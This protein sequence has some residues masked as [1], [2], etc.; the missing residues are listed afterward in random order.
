[1]RQTGVPHA[2][3]ELNP[4]VLANGC[5]AVAHGLLEAGSDGVRL[6]AT[7]LFIAMERAVG[8]RTVD[9]P[10][11]L[12]PQVARALRNSCVGAV[13]KRTY[14]AL[15][16]VLPCQIQAQPFTRVLSAVPR[17]QLRPHPVA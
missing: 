11:M 2:L 8:Q 5:S 6:N 17:I 1:M 4:S 10:P 7:V 16:N 3:R 15:R 13:S 9:E 12:L 14:C